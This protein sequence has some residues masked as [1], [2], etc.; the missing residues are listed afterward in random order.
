MTR[1]GIY[2]LVKRYSIKLR[3]QMPSLDAKRISSHTMRHST[4]SHLLRGG[5]EINTVRAW[6]GHIS[7]DTTK[8]YADIDLEMKAKVLARCEISDGNTPRRHWRSDPR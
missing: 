7:L 3:F 1:F 2:A 4:A 8:I 6:L 5:V